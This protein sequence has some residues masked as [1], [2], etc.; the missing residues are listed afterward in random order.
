MMCV[1]G[2]G[3]LKF[4]GYNFASN[5][6]VVSLRLSAAFFRVSS[7]FSLLSLIHSLLPVLSFWCWL[8]RGC[9]AQPKGGVT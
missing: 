3:H 4:C 2:S 6:V 9:L 8:R 1:R 7:V 5:F